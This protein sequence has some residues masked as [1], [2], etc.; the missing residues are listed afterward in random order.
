MLPVAASRRPA[1]MSALAGFCLA[2]FV[3]LVVRDLFVPRVRD[4]EVWFGLELRGPLALWTAPL[5]WAVFLVGAWGFWSQRPWILRAAAAYGF[6]IAASHLV[7]NVTSPVGYGWGSGLAQT[8]A[9]AIPA[10]LL[11]R[12]DRRR[13]AQTGG[14]GRAG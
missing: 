4:V 14:E 11:L 3:F 7:W 2:S 12:A 1:W 13:R 6:Y 10:V 9:F 5:H 8:V